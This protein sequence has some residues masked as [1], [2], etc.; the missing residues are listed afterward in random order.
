MKNELTE[1]EKE[2]IRDHFEKIPIRDL[3]KRMKRGAK[4]IYDFVKAEKKLVLDGSRR[5][6]RHHPWRSANRQLWILRY[7]KSNEES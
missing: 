2:F 1:Q 6:T 3:A 5:S 4:T 7:E